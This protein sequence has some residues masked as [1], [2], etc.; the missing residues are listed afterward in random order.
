MLE[1]LL[2]AEVLPVRILDPTRDCCLMAHL[3]EMLQIVQP[4][5]QPCW[6]R[7]ATEAFGI[8]FPEL[9]FK[10]LPVDDPRQPI[11]WML[12]I[13]QVLEQGGTGWRGRTGWHFPLHQ[14]T[15]FRSFLRVFWR[16]YPASACA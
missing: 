16:F 3:S 2:A 15:S 1:M 10:P 13:E 5:L 4:D 9:S 14:I 8:E 12:S 11:E 6:Q 7:R